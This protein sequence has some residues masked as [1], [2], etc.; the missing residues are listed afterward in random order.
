MM[1]AL[2][3]LFARGLFR[4][5]KLLRLSSFRQRQFIV[6]VDSFLRGCSFLPGWDSGLPRFVQRFHWAPDLVDAV[7]EQIT[8][9]DVRDGSSKVW[10]IPNELTK[11]ETTV[12]FAH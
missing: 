9:Q 3:E 8:D 1:A 10:V 12:V 5:L 2:P 4:N 7:C 6:L 11:A